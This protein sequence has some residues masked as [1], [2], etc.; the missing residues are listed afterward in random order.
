MKE[1]SLRVAAY[2]RTSTLLK[3][4]PKLQIANINEYVKSRSNMRVVGE[5][6]DQISGTK[7]KRPSL[8]Q[9]MADIRRGKV[10]VVV[11]A[12]LDRLGRNASHL[13]QLADQFREHD[14]GLISLREA[15]DLNSPSGRAFFTIMSAISEL[16]RNQISERIKMALAAK[17]LIA[18]KTSSGWRCGRKSILTPANQA[19]AIEL[20]K[21]GVSIR[22]IGIQ[23]GLAKSSVQ[24]LLSSVP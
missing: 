7:D 20:K 18:E 5:Y 24:K 15:L 8:D 6:I 23:M 19:R 16:D 2:A 17:K 3:Q 22:K 13:L 12:A 1:I 9:M 21:Q 4:D 11:I 14:V 10:D